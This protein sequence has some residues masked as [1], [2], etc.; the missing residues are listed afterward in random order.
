MAKQTTI[1]KEFS[2]EGVGLH[3][4]NK[5]KM[6]F[7]PAEKNTGIHF[8][9]VDL[10]N[11]PDIKADWNSLSTEA[12]IRGTTIQ[13]EKVQIHTIEHILSTCFALGIDN[14]IIEIVISDRK[15]K[16]SV[17]LHPGIGCDC[18]IDEIQH[19]VVHARSL[20]NHFRRANAFRIGIIIDRSRRDGRKLNTVLFIKDHTVN[21]V[22]KKLAFRTVHH[23]VADRD[24]SAKRFSSAFRIDNTGKPKHGA[25]PIDLVRRSAYTALINDL[26]ASRRIIPDYLGVKGSRRR[27]DR[28]VERTVDHPTRNVGIKA[29]AVGFYV[30]VPILCRN[31]DFKRL[32]AAEGESVRSKL[33]FQLF[34]LCDKRRKLLRVIAYEKRL[35]NKIPKTNKTTHYK[36]LRLIKVS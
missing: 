15:G 8:I 14:L 16:S 31:G 1:E 28:D 3:T 29:S 34:D 24:L 36:N 27:S 19:A 11:K 12:A 4:G 33:I 5:S 32:A 18:G 26:Y 10:P 9:R 30:T 20:Q 35:I 23:D 13:S 25:V 22:R 6:L 21:G 7:K 17:L 2:I